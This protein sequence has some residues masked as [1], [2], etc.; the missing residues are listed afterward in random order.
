MN[1]ETNRL[2]AESHMG[3]ATSE[4]YV[5][6]AVT[7]LESNVDS[8]NIRILASFQ[9]PLHSSEVDDYF[10]RCMKDLGWTM[11][12]RRECLL[13]YARDL[14][15]QILASDLSPLDGCSRIFKV[16]AAL[17]Y[18][19]E[20]TRWI[21]LYGGLNPSTYDELEGAEWDDEIKSEAALLAQ[22]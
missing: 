14:A 9:K 10:N 1:F 19:Q 17:D 16:V 7:C 13:Q 11:P 8:K 6:W 12:E 21:Y 20:L 2:L 3:L 18:P 15:Q 4:D 22:L 5:M